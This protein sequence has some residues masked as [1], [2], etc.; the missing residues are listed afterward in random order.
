MKKVFLTFIALVGTVSAF[1]Q[2]SDGVSATLQNGKT[3]TVYYGYDAFKDAI[4]AAPDAGGVITLSPGA[5]NNPGDI[6]K[7][8][9]IYGAGFQ[10]DEVTNVSETRVNG[11]FSIKSTD[12]ISPTV[13]LEGVYIVNDIIMSGTQKI[14]DTEIVKCSFNS[15][16]NRVETNN[17]IIR[18]CY[19]RYDIAGENCKATAL[20]VANC[21]YRYARGFAAGSQ[22]KIDH[23]I[24]VG[25]D[26]HNGPY[27]YSNNI[28]NH[29]YYAI[30]AGA[31][32]YYNVGWDG[33]F[34]SSGNNVCV[35]NYDNSLWKN[36]GT[37]F[38]DGQDNLNYTNSEGKPRTWVL[39]AP[40][41]YKGTDGTP[42]GVTGGDFPWNPIPATPRIISTSVDAKSEAGKLKVTI[43]AEARPIE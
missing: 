15:Y 9:K 25:G 34:S 37:L 18:Q 35:N 39:A 38:A 22:V 40:E 11:H 32:C 21:L 26:G 17:T 16:C 3:T 23:C 29:S 1:A 12:A 19:L 42:C 43:K 27:Y 31:T 36:W 8:V 13:R 30:D 41:T 7:S 28:M 6:S 14:E 33:I 5:F 4:A 24:I 20:V 2:I 10:T